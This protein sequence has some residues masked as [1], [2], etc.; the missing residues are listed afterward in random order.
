M[1]E[2]KILVTGSSGLIGSS[3]LPSLL[4][5]FGDVCSVEHQL[6]VNSGKKLTIDLSNMDATAL[7][8]EELRPNAII[9]LAAFTDV[10]HCE[11]NPQY[12]ALMNHQLVKVLIRH[13]Q[14][15]R[16]SN[17]KEPYILHIS[18][19]YIFDGNR[20][21]Y[22]EIDRP[23][24]INQYGVT[25]LLAEKAI[26]SS[27]PEKEWCIA[28]TSTP[29]GIHTKKK[30]FPIYVIE[31]LQNKQRINAVVDQYTS[32]TYTKNLSEMLLEILKKRAT[33]VFH[34]SGASRVSRFEQAIGI[35]EILN[36]DTRLIS[37]I[38]SSDMK[39]IAKR[40]KDSSLCVGRAYEKLSHKPEKFSISIAKFAQDLLS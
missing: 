18:T 39:W 17:N 27:L 23:N 8:L 40:P 28:R 1:A 2:D 37:G 16:I 9:N 29:F 31:K 20:G 10:D 7:M 36:L 3:L 24:P 22:S 4:E 33:G 32:P 38:A 19:D 15:S 11:T 21:H 25:K 30:T 26:I 13:I 12:A 14:R 34:L 35:A 6:T 5:V